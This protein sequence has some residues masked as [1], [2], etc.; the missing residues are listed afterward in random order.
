MEL[1]H[2]N[3]FIH[4]CGTVLVNASIITD[5][6]TVIKPLN[7]RTHVELRQEQSNTWAYTYNA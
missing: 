3:F 7:K 5:Y 6:T 1:S 2:C 4:Y